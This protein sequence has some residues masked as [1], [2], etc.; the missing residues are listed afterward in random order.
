MKTIEIAEEVLADAR[1]L[2]S[3]ELL[4]HW[5]DLLREEGYTVIVKP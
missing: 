4:Q 1:A 5:L 3:I 2:G